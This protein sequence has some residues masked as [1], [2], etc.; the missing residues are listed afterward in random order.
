MPWLSGSVGLSIIPY[1]K[2]IEGSIPSL[3]T[4]GRLPINVLS[5]TNVSVSL[6]SKNTSSGEDLKKKRTH[7][8][9]MAPAM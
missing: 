3:G 6:I 2:N 7:T 4:Y 5:H 8:S 9:Q 1:I